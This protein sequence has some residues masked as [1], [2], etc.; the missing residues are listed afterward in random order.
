MLGEIDCQL[1]EMAVECFRITSISLAIH[2]YVCC[3]IVSPN[4]H[5]EVG[6]IP[7]LSM[8]TETG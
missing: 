7:F 1:M 8:Q 2:R 5:R 3:L 4:E 6:N